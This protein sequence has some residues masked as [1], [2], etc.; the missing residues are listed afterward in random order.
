MPIRRS[1]CSAGAVRISEADI[2][3]RADCNP[4]W[5]IA[6]DYLI[7]DAGGFASGL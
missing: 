3:L 5:T 4:F 2:R 7:N 6:D 1:G